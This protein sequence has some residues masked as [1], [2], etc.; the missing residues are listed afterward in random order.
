[1]NTFIVLAFLFTVGSL[2][3]W[4]LEVVFRK[5]FSGANP[6]HKWINPGFLTGPYLPL[7][8]FG[9]VALYLIASCER[10]NMVRDP[11][12]NKLLL[13]AFMALCMTV[14]EYLAGLLTTRVLKVKLWDYSKLWGNIQ[15]II[16][17]LFSFFWAVLGALYYFL[18]HPRVLSAL[19]WL[20][21]N[22]A[23]SFAIG[24]FYGIFLLDLVQST[25]LMVRLRRFAA[26]QQIVIR[27]E[28]FKEHVRQVNNARRI[29]LSFFFSML[30]QVPDEERLAELLK[31]SRQSVER[32]RHRIR[33]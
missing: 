16:C 1:M 24:F 11:V 18:V 32:L 12:G 3:G 25:R 21:R 5:F 9:L 22:L 33:K 29:R 28:E 19:D 26:E 23:F 13:F 4:G 15:G 31:K 14:I 17:P 7:Y 2:L 6:E 20:S 10:Y 30:P 27:Y 8:G